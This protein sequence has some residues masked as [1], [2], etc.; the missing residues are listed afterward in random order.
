MNEVL[1][2]AGGLGTRLQ[3]LELGVSKPIAPLGS[4]TFLEH[5]I[6][7]LA[8]FGFRS[9]TLAISR[10][11]L[12]VKRQLHSTVQRGVHLS[13]SVDPKPIGT[14][15]AV[16][17]ALPMMRDPFLVVNGD[18]FFSFDPNVVVDAHR[19][20]RA[21]ATIA[22]V[23]KDNNGR[24]TNVATTPDGVITDLSTRSGRSRVFVS[25]GVVAISKAACAG[26][27]ARLPCSLEKD[28][29]PQVV[30]RRRAYAVK[31]KG[32]FWDIGTPHSYRYFQSVFSK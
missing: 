20:N 30:G 23:R 5:L 2:L 8:D 29:L 31:V 6:D 14:G 17:R 12:D 27:D 13:Y 4:R 15:S 22:I 7:R 25:A 10:Q 9:F 28:I 19:T 32:N 24:Y 18:T 3:P 26:F 1:V 21:D 16:V 11:T